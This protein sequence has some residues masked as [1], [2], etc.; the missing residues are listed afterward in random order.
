[1]FSNFLKIDKSAVCFQ[2]K[3][4][5]RNDSLSKRQAGSQASRRETWRLAL[6]QPVYIG[7]VSV[8]ALIWLNTISQIFL[9]DVCSFF[10][11]RN[12]GNKLKNE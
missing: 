11:E 7:I 12:Q 8:L 9:R 6:I 2:K 4:K 3:L 10:K 5:K 1:M